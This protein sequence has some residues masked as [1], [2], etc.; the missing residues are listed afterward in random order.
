MTSQQVS[1]TFNVRIAG[2]HL[3]ETVAIESIVVED[4]LHVPDMF[5]LTLRD[6]AGET[7]PA[8]GAAIGVPLE[9]SLVS[10]AA[11]S[12]VILI[13]GEITALEARITG[14]QTLIVIRGFD[15]SHRLFRGCQTASYRDMTY[16]EV[17][18]AVAQRSGLQPGAITNTRP[19]HEHITQAAESDWS[20]LTRLATEV[21]FEVAVRDGKLHFRPPASSD[22]APGPSDLSTD[23]PLSLL[24]GSDLFH[25]HATVTAADQVKEV[26]V[27]S[28]DQRRKQVLT[29]SAP[30]STTASVNGVS[31][32]GLAS[33]FGD[34]TLVASGTPYATAD[35]VEA[36]AKAL[37][38][39]VASSFTEIEA[40]T[41]GNHRLRAGEAIRIGLL[42][43]P[44][45]GTYVITSAEHRYDAE[46]GYVTNLV[47]SGR[48]ER[49]TFRLAGG[50]AL[51][52]ERISGVVPAIVDDVNDPDELCRVRL[53]FPWMDETYV[54]DWSRAAQ[55]GA[56]DRRGFVVI[57]EVGDEVLAAFEQGDVRR[58]YVIAGL[59]NGEDQPEVGPGAFLDRTSGAV[60]NRVFTSRVGHQLI[61][62]DA[63]SG[64]GIVVSTSDGAHVI[65]L[66]QSE[67]TVAVE[68]SGD[69][70]VKANG[71]LTIEAVGS[72]ELKG[73][74]MKLEASGPVQ[75][76]GA[77]VQ[78]N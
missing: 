33:A 25:V 54:S 58:P 11:T 37:V 40:Q 53:R 64:S 74:S 46:E 21:G 34:R 30:A 15:E 10:D 6:P 42:G 72:V 41:R 45:D 51:T 23:D 2:R 31:P 19:A 62:I 61:F 57:P 7:L 28:W 43:S 36:A 50:G 38:D 24:A 77:Q 48:Q 67:R 29:A 39:E 17:A 47:M 78:L 69:V 59:Y 68:S 76:K 75:I 1:N 44:F 22:A 65:R 16:S 71:N 4:H 5:V 13:T 56:G 27:R 18:R 32:A 35:E 70:I 9:I 73:Q 20:F 26:E 8:T 12:P 55:L 52:R 14:G 60:N 3:P 63:D 66:D 49:S